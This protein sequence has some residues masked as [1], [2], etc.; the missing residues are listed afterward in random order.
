MPQGAP[1]K[2][3][4]SKGEDFAPRDIDEA[5]SRKRYQKFASGQ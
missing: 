3:R 5:I 2:R 1:L 4:V